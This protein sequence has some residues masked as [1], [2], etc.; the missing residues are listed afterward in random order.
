MPRSRKPLVPW[1]ER[2]IRCLQHTSTRLPTFVIMRALRA[3]VSIAQI[4][5]LRNDEWV[6]PVV[7][8]SAAK[9]EIAAVLT[10]FVTCMDNKYAD[11]VAVLLGHAVP[12]AHEPVFV[13]VGVADGSEPTDS[14]SDSDTDADKEWAAYMERERRE[15]AR[16]RETRAAVALASGHAFPPPASSSQPPIGA[17]GCWR[18]SPTAFVLSFRAWMRVARRRGTYPMHLSVENIVAAMARA[19]EVGPNDAVRQSDSVS[20]WISVAPLVRVDDPCSPR[21]YLVPSPSRAAEQFGLGKDVT[22]MFLLDHVA[23][24]NLADVLGMCDAVSNVWARKYGWWSDG[25]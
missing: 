8:A 4:V 21:F 13:D 24:S 11:D 25:E 2:A 10:A 7:D 1:V 22:T 19:S 14:D 6:S 15:A 9:D 17:L 23:T 20:S 12:T 3:R 16:R 5:R 18:R